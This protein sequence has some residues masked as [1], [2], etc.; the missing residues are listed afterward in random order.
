MWVYRSQKSM[1]FLSIYRRFSCDSDCKFLFFSSSLSCS[2]RE[3][4]SFFF[5]LLILHQH[6]RRPTSIRLESIPLH[7]FSPLL[8]EISSFTESHSI[9][10]FRLFSGWFFAPNLLLDSTSTYPTANNFTLFII[11]FQTKISRF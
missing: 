9:A 4:H 6:T 7:N 3:L 10:I 8:T 2:S 11:A 1:C 5:L